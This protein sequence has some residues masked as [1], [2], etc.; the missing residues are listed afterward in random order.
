MADDV[1]VNRGDNFQVVVAGGGQVGSQR[2]N[3]VA[4]VVI[5]ILI[6]MQ[7]RAE[8]GDSRKR[9]G[10]LVGHSVFG[11]LDV[12]TNGNLVVSVPGGDGEGREAV[13]DIVGV[14]TNLK[15][16]LFN[17]IVTPFVKIHSISKS[18]KTT[19]PPHI[20]TLNCS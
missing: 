14:I 8:F 5:N 17:N 7:V 11:T 13:L 15:S 1:V 2:Y 3:F 18:V 6:G 4:A 16:P 9:K 12:L 19:L 10:S 20:P